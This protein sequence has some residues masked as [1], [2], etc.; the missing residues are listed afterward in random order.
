M[1]DLNSLI[2]HVI[3]I[4]CMVVSNIRPQEYISAAND[5][6]DVL[7]KSFKAEYVFPRTSCMIFLTSLI[8]SPITLDLWNLAVIYVI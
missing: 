5:F 1:P 8:L 2:D 4:G 3:K 6:R 7:N